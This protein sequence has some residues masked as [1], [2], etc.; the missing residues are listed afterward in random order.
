MFTRFLSCRQNRKQHEVT[1][2]ENLHIH[3]RNKIN[4][5]QF[6]YIVRMLN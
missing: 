1:F 6:H 4:K 2:Y 3:I 5:T